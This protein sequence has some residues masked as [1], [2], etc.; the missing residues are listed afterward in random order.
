M[1]GLP[2]WFLDGLEVAET[3]ELKRHLDPTGRMDAVIPRE[4]AAACVVT[5]GARI[6]APGVIENTTPK[7]N[8]LTLGFSDGRT[9]PVIA[10][11]AEGAVKGGYRAGFTDKIREGIW[12]KLFINAASAMVSALVYRSTSDTVS[13]PELHA[14]V[15]ACIREII[16]IGRA[17]G[18]EVNADP[19]GMADA[20]KPHHHRPSVLQ[21]LEAGRPLELGPTILAIRALARAANVSA[22]HLTTI[23]ALVSARADDI[24]KTAR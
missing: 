9:D 14:I 24:A 23:A 17:I 5:S 16:E 6:V 15:A 3:P 2:W 18:V 4:R 11:F 10:Q 21:D 19:V 7:V 8:I 12:A 20:L 1:N 13:D 22:P